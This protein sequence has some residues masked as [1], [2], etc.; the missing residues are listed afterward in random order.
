MPE[1]AWGQSPRHLLRTITKITEAKFCVQTKPVLSGGQSPGLVPVITT[2][3]PLN[4]YGGG[5]R[6][7]KNPFLISWAT[8]F[9]TLFLREHSGHAKRIIY[10]S[11][12]ILDYLPD[13]GWRF[14][15]KPKRVSVKNL[16]SFSERIETAGFKCGYNVYTQ[17]G[18]KNRVTTSTF[19]HQ[20][21]ADLKSAGYAPD[22]IALVMGHAVTKTQQYYGSKKS[23]RGRRFLPIAAAGTREIKDTSH[24]WPEKSDGPA[25]V[26]RG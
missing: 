21:S 9:C 16:K 4:G 10:F 15:E 23:G 20:V 26:Q 12:E 14:P 1:P 13:L 25:K 19:R 6:S 24:P 22:E 7:V 8:P 11:K 5:T 18:K 3:D 2:E 17:T